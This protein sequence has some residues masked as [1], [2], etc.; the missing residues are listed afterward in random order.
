MNTLIYYP[1]FSLLPLRGK[2][3]IIVTSNQT[4]VFLTKM[5]RGKKISD[6]LSFDVVT[7]CLDGLIHG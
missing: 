1:I 3:K 4:T 5:E 6:R 2:F 7:Y